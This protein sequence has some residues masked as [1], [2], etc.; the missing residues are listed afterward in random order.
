MKQLIQ[1]FCLLAL[2]TT[3]HAEVAH[4]DNEKTAEL[5][6]QEIPIIDVRMEKEWKQTGIVKGSHLLTFFDEKGDYDFEKWKVELD[7]VAGKDKPFMLIC[8]VGGRTMVI[9]QFLDKVQ[10]Y[11]KVHNV[12]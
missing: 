2:S 9:S 5:L 6:K 4:I 7:K 3:L 11:S 8:A 10:G 12:S 1:T